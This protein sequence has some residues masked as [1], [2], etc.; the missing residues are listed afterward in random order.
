MIKILLTCL[1]STAIANSEEVMSDK[2]EEYLVWISVPEDVIYNID[3]KIIYT[4]RRKKCFSLT[5][6]T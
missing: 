2:A 5:K 6:Y 3:V 4:F 1:H